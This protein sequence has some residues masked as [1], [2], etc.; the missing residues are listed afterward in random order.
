MITQDGLTI[1]REEKGKVEAEIQSVKE[2]W[3]RFEIE[4]IDGAFYFVF[5]LRNFFKEEFGVPVEMV[6]KWTKAFYS[7][8]D[9]D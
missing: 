3:T 6:S 9:F 2:I 8:I 7:L 1:A 4:K 5:K